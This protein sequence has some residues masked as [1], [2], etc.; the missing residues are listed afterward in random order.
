MTNGAFQILVCIRMAAGTV[1]TAI[2]TTVRSANAVMTTFWRMF[3]WGRKNIWCLSNMIDADTKK[4]SVS[5]HWLFH[6]VNYHPLQKWKISYVS[7]LSQS[8][9]SPAIVS[10]VEQTPELCSGPKFLLSWPQ[11]DTEEIH[12]GFWV[13]PGCL[14]RRLCSAS[15]TPL[16]AQ[17]CSS[18]MGTSNTKGWQGQARDCAV[19]GIFN[20]GDDI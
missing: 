2:V 18:T 14:C 15:F 16:Q 6:A 17:E 12:G 13:L 20:S 1:L 10:G 4:A 8:L 5:N 19:P 7:E 3:S 9:V 11:F